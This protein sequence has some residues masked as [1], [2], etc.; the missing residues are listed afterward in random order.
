MQETLPLGRSEKQR[1]LNG[2]AERLVEKGCR[3]PSAGGS[4]RLLPLRKERQ[5]EDST[6]GGLKRLNGV[7]GGATRSG[8]AAFD[9]SSLPAV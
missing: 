2:E 9:E 6:F 8:A 1:G 3:T 5:R 4:L 7:F